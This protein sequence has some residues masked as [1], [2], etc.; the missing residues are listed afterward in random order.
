MYIIILYINLR[1]FNLTNNL[2][3]IPNTYLY[4]EGNLRKL[5]A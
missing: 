3:T 5:G 1:I 4:D 2:N